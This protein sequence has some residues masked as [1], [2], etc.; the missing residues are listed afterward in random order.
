MQIS[1]RAPER[2]AVPNAASMLAILMLLA[3]ILRLWLIAANSLYMDEANSVAIAQLDLADLWR[4]VASREANMAL[5]F[6]F[7]HYWVHFGTSEFALRMP[8]AVFSTVTIPVFYALARRLFDTRVALI[9][10]LLLCINALHLESA[11]N[12]RSYALLVLLVTS[13]NLLLLHAAELPN[14]QRCSTYT[15]VTVLALYAHFFSLLVVAAQTSFLVLARSHSK[16]GR[17]LY[18]SCA[19]VV[20]FSVP[21]VLFIIFR[22]TGQLDWVPRTGFWT[23][24]GLFT[25][26]SGGG[27]GSVDISGGPAVERMLLLIYAV[28]LASG[29]V[30]C[31]KRRRVKGHE[32]LEFLSTAL[33]IP[34]IVAIVVSI[35]VQ[36]IFFPHYLEICLPPFLILVAA[37]IEFLGARS[38]LAGCLGV[39]AI[40]GLYEDVS[41]YKYSVKADFRDA[42]DYIARRGE[43]G[44]GV[45]IYIPDERWPFAY[46]CSH[47]ATGLRCPEIVFPGL[48]TRFWIGGPY[49]SDSAPEV[50]GKEFLGQLPCQYHRIWL[51]LYEEDAVSGTIR[52]ILNRNY[53]LRTEKPFPELNLL[54]YDAGKKRWPLCGENTRD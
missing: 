24:A 21:I 26:L 6:V 50:P 38:S 28:F 2:A 19:V 34:I 46:Y 43:P 52:N 11:Q 20:L 47:L 10:C 31:A 13:S 51:V 23:V 9:A 5:Y 39:I 27:Y 25:G 53:V 30:V 49:I 35:G 37:G 29:L 44:D 12:A 33:F 14:L 16:V 15:A 3:L 17:P 18:A 7:L 45:I 40:L 32:C 8:S 4:M 41:Y 1:K 22:N 36:P 54:L 48:N 42:V